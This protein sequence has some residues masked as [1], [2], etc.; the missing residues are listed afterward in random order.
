MSKLYNSST[1][2]KLEGLFFL[3]EKKILPKQSQ[4]D[5]YLVL[6]DRKVYAGNKPK[7]CIYYQPISGK[8][9][10]I[11]SL[12]PLGINLYSM[13]YMGYNYKLQITGNNSV[14]ITKG[15]RKKNYRG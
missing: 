6:V 10:Y 5:G 8:S 14:I 7:N 1:N 15:R 9:V 11:S 4:F 3:N 2:L 12:F 13:D